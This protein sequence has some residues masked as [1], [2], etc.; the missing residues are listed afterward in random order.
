MSSTSAFQA[1][2]A[3]LYDIVVWGA[4]GYTGALIARYLA[5]LAASERI[6]FAIAG[7]SHTKL[8]ALAGSVQA[9]PTST[10][11]SPPP[12]LTADLSSADSLTALTSQCRTLVAAA[13]PFALHGEPILAACIATETDY[14]DITGETQW[15][16]A[17][18]DRYQVPAARARVVLLP[19][20]GI[21]SLPS[22]LCAVYALQQYERRHRELLND[23]HLHTHA[24]LKGALSG[25]TAATMLIA[26]GGVR[27]PYLLALPGYAEVKA[28]QGVVERLQ[29]L[30]GWSSTER[31]F[32]APF[33]MSTVNS[34]AVRRTLSFFALRDRRHTRVTYAED[35]IPSSSPIRSFF[36]SVGWVVALAVF[37]VSLA[38]PPARALLRRFL[39]STG[40]G[41][42][43]AER[44]QY[45]YRWRT[46]ARERGG[47]GR[48]A[49]VEMKGGEMYFETARLASEVA[50]LMGRER[51]A[52]MKKT[53][54]GAS[55]ASATPWRT[56]SERGC[57][58]MERRHSV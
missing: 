51:E 3:R 45:W 57:R 10:L 37:V 48:S 49:T 35:Q 9:H 19:M 27:Q 21:D 31:T 12:I 5:Q 17:M 32:T 6:T 43:D 29:L 46:T 52:L 50:I 42:S 55:G 14:A 24:R 34:Q 47:R 26:T 28:E 54:G 11:S 8:A 36:L 2:S 38:L 23:G 18:Y 1:R 20:A 13:G 39:P 33:V 58:G 16:R 15:V 4:T 30:P 7:R 40:E 22:E 56:R 41:P 25:G 53:G 44:H